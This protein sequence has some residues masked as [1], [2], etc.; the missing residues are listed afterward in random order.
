MAFEGMLT[1]KAWAVY[2]ALY[3]LQVKIQLLKEQ[4]LL[5]SLQVSIRV[6]S[7]SGR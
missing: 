4:N 3:F 1:I 6:K 2:N 5:Q 7:L